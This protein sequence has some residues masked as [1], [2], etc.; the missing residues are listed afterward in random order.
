[1]TKEVITTQL[2]DLIKS[3]AKSMNDHNISVCR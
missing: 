2:S 1:M 3:A